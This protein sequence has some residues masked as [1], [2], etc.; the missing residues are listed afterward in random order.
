MKYFL[1]KF[2][3]I[4]LY[5]FYEILRYVYDRVYIKIYRILNH[6]EYGNLLNK[7]ESDDGNYVSFVKKTLKNK[8]HFKNFKRNPIYRRILDHNAYRMG[9]DYLNE[10]QNINQK[11]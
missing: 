8:Y 7:S 3:R 2:Q 4:K 10:I 11:F 6:D 5:T 1:Q 9:L